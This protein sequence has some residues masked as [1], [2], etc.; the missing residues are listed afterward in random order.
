M[1][2]DHHQVLELRAW[3]GRLTTDGVGTIL[4]V[5]KAL[6]ELDPGQNF[7]DDEIEQIMLESCSHRRTPSRCPSGSSSRR[8]SLVGGRASSPQRGPSGGSPRLLVVKQDVAQQLLPR[9]RQAVRRDRGSAERRGRTGRRGCAL[10]LGRRQLPPVGAAGHG[11]QPQLGSGGCPQGIPQG[12]P[13][14]QPLPVLGEPL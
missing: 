9:R 12:E 14:F 1:G 11:V 13:G 5:R 8:V 7:S 2:L 4:N 6:E 10:R 3:W